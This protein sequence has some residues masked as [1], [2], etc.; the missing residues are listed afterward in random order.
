M[1]INVNCRNHNKTTWMK[2]TGLAL[3]ALSLSIS[4]AYAAAAFDQ[5][6]PNFTGMVNAMGVNYAGE[7]V[8]INGRSFSPGQEVILLQNGHVLTEKALKADDK[9]NFSTT[10]TLPANAK[11]GQHAIVVQATEPSAATVF[12]L[13]VSTKFPESGQEKFAITTEPLVPGVYQSAYSPKNDAIFVTSAVGRPPVLNSQLLK[14]DPK[15]LKII[16]SITPAAQEGRDDGQVQAVYGVAVDDANGTVWV[17]NTR[18]GSVAVYK[19][20]DL[21][22]VKQFDNGAAPHARDVVIDSKKQRAYV[23]TP[24][25]PS[26]AVFDTKELKELPAIELKSAGRDR[27]SPLSLAF[28]AEGGLLYTVALNTNELFVIDLNKNETTVF[29]LPGALT[30]SGVAIDAKRGHAYV[31]SQGSDNVLIV[32]TK[33]GKVLQDVEIGAGALNVVFDPKTDLAYAVSRGAG[34]L[35]VIQADGQILANLNLGSMPNHISL[36]GKGN[37]YAVTKAQG[38]DDALGGDRISRIQLKK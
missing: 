12:K 13:K 22:L 32:D 38:K 19:Q 23:S 9:G 3:A 35:T 28:D 10:I 1:Q 17:T 18:S 16:S 14:V 37:A 29:A 36:D 33:D 11:S 34:T 6:D 26:V 4:S 27:P 2:Q 15:T 20:A 8:N 24:G 7:S 31:A 21:S 30:A 25:T 5:A